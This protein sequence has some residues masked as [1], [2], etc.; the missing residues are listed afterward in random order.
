M[1][2]RSSLRNRSFNFCEISDRSSEKM[3]DLEM[4]DNTNPSDLFEDVEPDP[5]KVTILNA[6]PKVAAEIL[7]NLATK[8]NGENP[9][10]LS[11]RL[12][13][14]VNDVEIKPYDIN[15]KKMGKEFKIQED[16]LFRP[17][18]LDDD[19]RKFELMV[20]SEFL[21]VLKS[22]GYKGAAY[23]KNAAGKPSYEMLEKITLSESK[24]IAKN[25]ADYLQGLR[26]KQGGTTKRGREEEE[27]EQAS[28]EYLPMPPPK[29]RVEEEEFEQ[30]VE[31]RDVLV[32]PT[33]VELVSPATNGFKLNFDWSSYKYTE[34]KYK[35]AQSAFVRILG[36]QFEL[37]TLYPIEGVESSWKFKLSSSSSWK[38][39]TLNELGFF[40]VNGL[41]LA[42]LFTGGDC[43]K[44]VNQEKLKK[45]KEALS[46][47]EQYLEVFKVQDSQSYEE[48]KAQVNAVTHKCR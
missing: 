34:G 36:T 1:T 26:E 44:I 29:K 35:G 27:S 2:R 6:P 30:V 18:L 47:V 17:P 43:V 40:T 41:S 4:D 21:S 37:V 39:A 48:L 42:V 12:K 13:N 31:Q 8:G 25:K 19:G 28:A 20:F 32:N 11:Y 33:Q 16:K 46:V 24:I 10:K 9:P 14:N 38:I 23:N 3:D 7:L 45:A 22:A 5:D 15:L